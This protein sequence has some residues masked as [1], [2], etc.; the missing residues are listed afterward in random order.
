[1]EEINKIYKIC[2][3]PTSKK[4]ADISFVRDFPIPNKLISEMD[5][6]SQLVLPHEKTKYGFTYFGDLTQ[7]ICTH[8]AVR[9]D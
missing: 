6:A 1:M 7:F 2:G 3:L 8:A 4:T 9:N 5:D